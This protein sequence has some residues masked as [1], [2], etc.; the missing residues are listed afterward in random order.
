MA[1]RWWDAV[2]PPYMKLPLAL[3]NAREGGILPVDREGSPMGTRRCTAIRPVLDLGG[4]YND[5]VDLFHDIGIEPCNEIH[6]AVR[7]GGVEA[8]LEYGEAMAAAVDQAALCQCGDPTHDYAV[9]MGM[10][11]GMITAIYPRYR[12][13]SQLAELHHFSTTKYEKLLS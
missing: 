3:A 8:V 12:A 7:H 2:Y 10:G 4:R 11:I 1:L 6:V 9:D 13:W 5:G